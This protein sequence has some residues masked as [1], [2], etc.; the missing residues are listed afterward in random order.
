MA[1]TTTLKLTAT[2]IKARRAAAEAKAAYGSVQKD[3]IKGKTTEKIMME[4][5]DQLLVG[6][7]DAAKARVDALHRREMA[8]RLTFHPEM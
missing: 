7:L 1:R 5:W 6:D 3:L 2:E 4:V 8:H